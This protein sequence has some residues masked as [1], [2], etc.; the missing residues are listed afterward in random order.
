MSHKPDCDS[1]EEMYEGKT[2]ARCE[3]CYKDLKIPDLLE[4]NLLVFQIW[5][6]I[7]DQLIM[8]QG[9]PV[10]LNMDIAFKFID[11]FKIEGE[12]RIRCSDLLQLLYYKVRLPLFIEAKKEREEKNNG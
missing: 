10:S 9:G 2:K 4:E 8:G 1:C 11:E 5:I 7:K 6:R 3:A 12:E